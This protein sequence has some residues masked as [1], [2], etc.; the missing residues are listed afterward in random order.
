MKKIF[1]V[2]DVH[3]H[4][5]ILKKALADAGFD[6][7]NEEHLL[8]CCGDY[9]DRGNENVEVLR[10]FEGLP[11][12]VLLR[13]NH[14]DMLLKL[15]QT[16]Q[17]LPHHYINGTLKT[18]ESFFGKFAIDPATDTVDF[19]GKTRTVDRLTEFIEGTVDYF[20]TEQYVFVHGWLPDGDFR[21]ATPEQWAQART[22]RWSEHY[23]GDAPIPGKT[24]ICGHMPAVYAKLFDPSRGMGNYTP[25]YGNGMIAIDGATADSQLVNI[26]VLEDSLC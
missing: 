18:V 17:L 16:G 6:K 24:L 12:A 3:G 15:L 21:Q 23:R 19:T 7:N 25:Y 5:E 11:N 2:S 20:E 9:F 1:V 14:E 4:C 10:F 13:G 22:K 8:I 26:I